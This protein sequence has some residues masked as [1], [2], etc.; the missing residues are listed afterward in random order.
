MRALRAALQGLALGYR[1]HDEWVTLAPLMHATVSN[2]AS[3]SPDRGRG[4]RYLVRSPLLTWHLLIHLPL[5][6]III[7]CGGRHLRWRGGESLAHRAIRAWSAGL[8]RVFGFRVRRY[9]APAP[10]AVM[11][12]ANHVSWLDI[13]LMHSQRMMGFVAKSEISRWPLIGWLARQADTIYHQRG[14]TESLGAVAQR[15]VE[16]LRSGHSVAVFPEG[17]TTPGAAVGIFHA[18][19]FQ[20]AMEA[21]V[22]VQAVALRYARNGRF[23]LQLP[24]GEDESFFANFVRILGEPTM[25]AEVHFLTTQ[26]DLAVGRRKIAEAARADIVATLE[27][28]EGA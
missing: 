13:E 5:T 17:G 6:L 21:Q 26:T 16:R 22:P 27:R 14:S 24:F 2:T 10:G 28:H 25:D 11:F 18:R 4:L 3:N 15:M 20:V 12:V 23:N 1:L 8:M 7:T 9:G 19:I